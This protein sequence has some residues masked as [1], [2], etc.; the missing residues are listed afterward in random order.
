MPLLSYT[1][2][3]SS[4]RYSSASTYMTSCVRESATHSATLSR[5]YRCVAGG[6]APL[7]RRVSA[8]TSASSMLR[9]R[10]QRSKT[11]AANASGP[12][13]APRG[14]ASNSS[15]STAS[16]C[17]ESCAALKRASCRA[18]M[19][20]EAS[21]SR[22]MRARRAISAPPCA[23]VPCVLSK[24]TPRSHSR[25]ARPDGCSS[26]VA[27]SSM[28]AAY[29]ADARPALNATEK[30]SQ[31]ECGPSP[32]GSGWWAGWWRE[33]NSVGHTT[34]LGLGAGLGLGLGLGL[35]MQG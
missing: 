1:K 34:W 21:E 15:G 17:G 28:R 12:K 9:E 26:A 8:I 22:S 18:Y 25:G 35:G 29:C 24:A 13:L 4:R 30:T 2:E 33:L 6:Q 31:C 14:T 23:A 10:K 16:C 19:Y 7:L 5:Q 11:H 20:N 3:G 27:A 32:R